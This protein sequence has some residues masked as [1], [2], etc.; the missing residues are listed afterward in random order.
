VDVG[1]ALNRD[2]SKGEIV[3]A[4]LDNFIERRDKMRRIEE[5]E[6]RE[7]EAWKESVRKANAAREAELREQWSSYHL[8]QAERHKAVLEDLVAHHKQQAQKLGAS[9]GASLGGD[10]A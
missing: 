2:I 3:D 1:K 9:L 6:R 10:A 5:G 7:E 4:D 8:D